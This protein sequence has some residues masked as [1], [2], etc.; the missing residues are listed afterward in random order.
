M[1]ATQRHKVRI[2]KRRLPQRGA[3]ISLAIAIG[4][5]AIVFLAWRVFRPTPPVVAYT[6]TLGD[7]LLSYECE[8]GHA[9]NAPGRIGALACPT[10][11]T[12]SYPRTNYI[13][14]IHNE[15]PVEV[16]FSMTPDGTERVSRIRVPEGEWKT[17]EEGVRC[18]K[19]R[20]PLSQPKQYDLSH[21]G[22]KPTKQK[23]GERPPPRE[24]PTTSDRRG[25]KAP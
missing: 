24:A 3:I 12:P 19:C 17:P 23:P 22:Q 6:R 16:D 9:F 21:L 18:S 7:V 10:C 15:Q 25:Q 20:S 8:R 1:K 4:A 13:C 11:Q 5:S 2:V 14:P